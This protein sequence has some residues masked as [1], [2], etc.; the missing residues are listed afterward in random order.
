[1]LIKTGKPDLISRRAFT[2]A[3]LA[4]AG[5]LYAT[6]AHALQ[7]RK[8]TAESAMG[9]F[10]PVTRGSESDADL[11]MLRGH[12]SR[13]MGQVIQVSG[14]VL[15]RRGNPISGASLE[16]WQANAAGR[17][18]HPDDVSKAALDP[19]FQGYAS[20]RTDPSGA[21]RIT[22]IKPAGYASPIGNRP[23]HIHFD[24]RGKSHRNIAQLYFPEDAA[25][26]AVDQLYRELGADA[27]TSV[28][29]RDTADPNLYSWDIVLL[30]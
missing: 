15:D 6:G 17:Y 2:R 27:A 16:I 30:G 12:S 26:N 11:T 21:W 4:S 13:A 22:T 28:A 9:P 23:P 1:M 24:V 18:E 20:I 7:D 10:Y 19:N 8:L 25:A 14:R 29:V 3:G 5:L